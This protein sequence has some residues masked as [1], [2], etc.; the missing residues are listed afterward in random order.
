MAIFKSVRMPIKY[1]FVNINLM[2]F[3]ISLKEI[4]LERNVCTYIYGI[5]NV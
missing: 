3:S 4:M 2:P 5:G 1:A